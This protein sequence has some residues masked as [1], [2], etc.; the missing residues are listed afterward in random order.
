MN[1]RVDI[2][3]ILGMESFRRYINR[4]DLEH[5]DFFEHDVKLEI[6]LETIRQFGFVGLNNMDFITSEYYKHPRG[7]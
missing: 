1:P 3:L 5:V 7:E 2:E 6:P 4:L